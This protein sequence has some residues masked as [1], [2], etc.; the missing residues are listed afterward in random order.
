MKTLSSYN[1]KK[2][3][4]KWQEKWEQEEVFRARDD[5]DKKKFYSLVE[6]PYPSGA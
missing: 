4:K 5:S 2:T 3:E 6:F 1:F